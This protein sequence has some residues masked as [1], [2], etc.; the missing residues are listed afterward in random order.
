ML[1]VTTVASPRFLPDKLSL[2]PEMD[3][4][5]DRIRAEPSEM[6]EDVV[7]IMRNDLRRRGFAVDAVGP[8]VV[9]GVM[10]EARRFLVAPPTSAFGDGEANDCRL[11]LRSTASPAMILAL[12]N[13]SLSEAFIAEELSIVDVLISPFLVLVTVLFWGSKLWS[14]CFARG[15]VKVIA[16]SQP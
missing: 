16:R 14:H 12:S 6:T 7:G 13:A 15:E 9:T 5:K 11:R 1:V 2:L 3:P 4:E 10:V 8:V